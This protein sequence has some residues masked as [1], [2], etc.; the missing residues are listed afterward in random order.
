MINIA[1]Q[2]FTIENLVNMSIH[3]FIIFILFPLFSMVKW[4]DLLYSPFFMQ[5]VHFQSTIQIIAALR[6]AF[7]LTELRCTLNRGISFF[8]LQSIN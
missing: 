6:N 4:G 7:K 5:T 3:R 2:H 8:E 1:N